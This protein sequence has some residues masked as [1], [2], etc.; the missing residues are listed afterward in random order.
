MTNQ[1]ASGIQKVS[2]IKTGRKQ[3]VRRASGI[4]LD[5]V[6]KKCMISVQGALT[7]HFW[8]CFFVF[9]EE[10]NL[11]SLIRQN[12]STKAKKKCCIH[13]NS[14]RILVWVETCNKWIQTHIPFTVHSHQLLQCSAVWRDHRSADALVAQNVTQNSYGREA[15]YSR[16]HIILIT[17]WL[18]TRQPHKEKKKK[19]TY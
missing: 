1:Q 6:Y 7:L 19:R 18:E 13:Q 12:K 5:T 15:V 17:I 11:L 14:Q 2:F 8:V 10:P 16:I 4:I 3:G 9:L